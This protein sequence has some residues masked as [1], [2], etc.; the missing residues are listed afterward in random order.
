MLHRH[1]KDNLSEMPGFLL[2]GLTVLICGEASMLS[3]SIRKMFNTSWFA[4]YL[5]KTLHF[6]SFSQIIG[7][8]TS[9]HE[10]TDRIHQNKQGFEGKKL[11]GKEFL[12]FEEYQ[13]VC[14]EDMAGS[15]NCTQRFSILFSYLDF[16]FLSSRILQN[17][18]L[19]LYLVKI[20]RYKLSFFA[21][22]AT[23]SL[24][25]FSIFKIA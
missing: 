11:S 3:A 18:L 2:G 25:H 23:N 17:N 4:V 10:F 20:R 21:K 1:K 13:R 8:K 19:H 14:V 24:P 16:R 12:A 22:R 5:Q 7:L 15:A 9:K 6:F